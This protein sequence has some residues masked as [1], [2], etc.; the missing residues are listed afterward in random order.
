[1]KEVTWPTWPATCSD[2]GTHICLSSVTE[3]PA[4]SNEGLDDIDRPLAERGTRNAEEM[5]HRL[6]E[7]GLV[8]ELIFASPANRALNTALIMAEVWDLDR[9]YL[10]NSRCLYMAYVSEIDQVVAGLLHEVTKLA[11]FGHN[12][13][14]T[15]YANKF[16]DTSPGQPAHCRCGYCNPG[17]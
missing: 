14:F 5:A 4:G 8:P 2:H 6:A 13:S 16:L 10:R 9:G 3:N 7:L 11:I 15:L 17:K 1:M 12:P